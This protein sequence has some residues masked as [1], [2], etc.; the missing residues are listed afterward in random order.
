MQ[1]QK[2]SAARPRPGPKVSPQIWLVPFFTHSGCGLVS[3]L[4]VWPTLSYWEVSLTPLRDFYFGL[5][6]VSGCGKKEGDPEG[7]P[8]RLSCGELS[9]GCI[10]HHLSEV[11]GCKLRV[12]PKKKDVTSGVSAWSTSSGVSVLT[13][14]PY[15]VFTG[16]DSDLSLVVVEL[17]TVAWGARRRFCGV[18]WRLP[19]E[20]LSPADVLL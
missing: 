19:A 9:L 15:V 6:P 10:H 17:Y 16:D 1:E 7:L 13:P 5:L 2:G 20:A 4:R 3:G 12:S 11:P 18:L 8:S 14:A